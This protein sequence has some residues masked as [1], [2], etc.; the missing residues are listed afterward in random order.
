SSLIRPFA[1]PQQSRQCQICQSGDSSGCGSSVE[2]C[3]LTGCSQH[4]FHPACLFASL[5]GSDLTSCPGQCSPN[6][7][8]S[9]EICFHEYLAGLDIANCGDQ[10]LKLDPSQHRCSVCFEYPAGEVATPECC[11]H[12]FCL[13]CLRHWSEQSDRCPACR[14]H[15][16]LLFCYSRLGG[17]L[18]RRERLSAAD[19]RPAAAPGMSSGSVSDL[20][21]RC[22]RR[23]LLDCGVC[24]RPVADRLAVQCA[25]CEAAF[26]ADCC[27]QQQPPS[28][29]SWLC[30][31]CR[32][33]IERAVEN[34]DADNSSSSSS[35][36]GAPVRAGRKRVAAFSASSSSSSTSSTSPPVTRRPRVVRPAVPDSSSAEDADDSAAAGA[37]AAVLT[38]APADAEAVDRGVEDSSSKSPA[39]GDRHCRLCNAKF[40]RY[41]FAESCPRHRFHLAC[42]LAYAEQRRRVT[43]EAAASASSTSSAT[44]AAALLCPVPNC[45]I[46]FDSVTLR[47][48]P[49]GRIVD[50]IDFAEHPSF[51]CPVCCEP[52]SGRVARPDCCRHAFCLPCLTE[53]CRTANTCPLDRLE[54]STVMVA[55]RF[56][57]AA[58][59]E[60]IAAPQPEQRQQQLQSL[61]DASD[62]FPTIDEICAVCYQG[63]REDEL[64]L[65]DTCDAAYHLDCL[66]PPLAAVPPGQW[67]CPRCP[68]QQQRRRRRLRHPVAS[69]RRFAVEEASS[70][71]SIADGVSDAADGEIGEDE[72]RDESMTS[73]TA[74]STTTTAT[75]DSDDSDDNDDESD[76]DYRPRRAATDRPGSRV[77][78]GRGRGLE[79]VSGVRQRLRR[80]RPRSAAVAAAAAIAAFPEPCLSVTDVAAARGRSSRRPGRPTAAAASRSCNNNNINH[81]HNRR[82]RLSGS[83]AAAGRGRAARRRRQ[84]GGGRS[85]GTSSFIVDD[86]DD[87]GD[88]SSD[89]SNESQSLQEA[90]SSVRSES[91][92]SV[93]TSFE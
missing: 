11:D 10:V 89:A 6:S 22:G 48:R 50:R 65:C 92:D 8:S 31:D 58:T 40:T 33:A 27:R 61:L 46:Q 7:S 16:R 88:D 25:D 18:L 73:S 39:C 56:G 83:T 15:Y 72:Q 60:R 82:S 52:I 26:H 37:A 75:A 59:V 24:R 36:I 62:D 54:F 44:A 45:G 81:N 85:A 91:D 1:A 93:Q 80:I 43:D 38:T 4:W 19:V 53:W 5:A 70:S 76:L 13:A 3:H 68:Q 42:L 57:P 64:L 55:S 78:G 28:A 23:R 84:A 86:D 79:S 51:S 17:P 20:F 47:R 87:N 49:G 30:P 2:L 67:N 41:E 77:A 69:R 21:R 34:L 74:T 14:R 29:P 90:A 35:P 32:S 12:A 63:D 9:N 66:D 71:S